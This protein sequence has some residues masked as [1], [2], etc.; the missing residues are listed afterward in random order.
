MYVFSEYYLIDL[1]H[2]ASTKDFKETNIKNTTFQ[3]DI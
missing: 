2:K 1:W 3:I